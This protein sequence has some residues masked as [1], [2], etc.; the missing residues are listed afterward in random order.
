[1]GLRFF[2]FVVVF[3]F[4]DLEAH[5]NSADPNS[6]LTQKDIFILAGQS[7]MAGRG[8]LINDVATGTQ[9][10]D[11]VV[12]SACRPNPSVLRL[13]AKLNWVEAHEPLHADIDVA[14]A[15]GVGPAMAFANAVLAQKPSSFGPIG[16][17]PCAIGGTNI[18]QWE[19][20]SLLY[21]RMVRRA[22]A[23]AGQQGGGGGGTLRALLWYQGESDTI[24]KQD[25]ESY[26]RRLEKLFQDIRLDL[27]S[28]MLPIIQV[29]LA[30]GEGR[31]VD[32]VREAQF[33][34]D[35]L[36]L[37]T[38]DAMGL[39][40]RPDK[41]HLTTESQV[42]LGEMVADAFLKFI[43]NH[44]SAT[45]NPINANF[46]QSTTSPT[47]LISNFIFSYAMIPLLTIL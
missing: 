19:R 35:L 4:R 42:R 6:Q 46:D 40:L 38:V 7:N 11:G 47:L 10:W 24:V 41:L 21:R 34:T 23:A 13:D 12:P 18:S 30:S 26:G 31:F 5:A 2:F 44:L 3:V 43:P 45:S 17:V 25:A 28:P 22:R 29:A 16:L 37:R 9:I 39:T 20:R 8:G 14:S 32:I 27:M 36:N 33:G 1:M 15:D